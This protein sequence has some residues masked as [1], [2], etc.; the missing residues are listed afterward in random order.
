MNKQIAK[1]IVD[2]N[3]NYLLN[4]KVFKVNN[5]YLRVCYKGSKYDLHRLVAI[6]YGDKDIK[7]MEVH[8]K[9]ENKL[10]NDIDNL[11]IMSKSEH[12]ILHNTGKKLSKEAIDQM[13]IKVNQYNKAGELLKTYDSFTQAGKELNISPGNINKACRGILKTSGGFIWKYS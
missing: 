7:G 10:N 6:A 1:L 13:S 4:N 2:R 12:I 9:D 3:G 11:E 8:H 5:G